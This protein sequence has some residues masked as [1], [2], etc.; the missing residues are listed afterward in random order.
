MKTITTSLC[1]AALA[2]AS[3]FGLV[4]ALSSDAWADK[5][6]MCRMKGTWGD[7]ASDVFEFD[8]VYV[9]RNGPDTFNGVYDNPGASSK[10]D[11]KGVATNGTWL[12]LL[13]YTD[14]TH[15]GMIKELKGAGMKDPVTHLLNVKGNY[16]T[17]IGTSDIGKNGTFLLE[18]KCH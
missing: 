16:R 13:T 12:I 4:S 17:L 9:A 3:S 1:A 6:F 14:S 8:A 2:A 10:A 5:Q 11:I 15:K 7:A 18:G